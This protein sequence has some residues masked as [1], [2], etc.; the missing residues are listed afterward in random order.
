VLSRHLPLL[1]AAALSFTAC[2]H[3]PAVTPAHRTASPSARQTF[4][5]PSKALGETRTINVYMPP[6]YDAGDRRY[7]ILY[8]PDGGEAEDFPHVADAVDAGIRAGE[9]EPLIVVG[10]ENT[11]RRRDMTG[12]TTVASDR[13]I[14]VR[15]G[16]SAAF[17][18]FIRDELMPAVRT[19]VRGNGHTGII[20]ES[21]A[22]LFIMETFFVAP[23]TFD[24][25]IALSPS[26][27]W[28]DRGLVREAEA[29]RAATP[30]LHK[31]LYLSVAGDDD[32]GDSILAMSNRLRSTPP[33][34]L[35]S[36]YE[37]RPGERHDTIYRASEGPALRKVFPAAPT[38]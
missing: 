11:E 31:T 8:M 21:L 33:E 38:R 3:A 19:R 24:V 34:G 35:S 15:V 14:A 27:W 37:P 20:G 36:L 7:P 12:P 32:R 2:S 28:N 18:A 30:Q 23:D 17:R 1:F 4:K 5:L 16:G 6:G 10:I 25:Y 13:A 9:V 22:G 26:L 29:W